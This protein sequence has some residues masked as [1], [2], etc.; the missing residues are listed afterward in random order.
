[1]A[2]NPNMRPEKTSAADLD[3]EHLTKRLAEGRK[4]DGML[5]I[6]GKKVDDPGMT[7]A[8]WGLAD[9]VG[10]ARPTEKARG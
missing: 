7:P 6:P 4:T 10:Q 2:R 9:T 5:E 3:R 1:M 8:Y